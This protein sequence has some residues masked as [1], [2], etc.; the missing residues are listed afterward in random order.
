[1]SESPPQA[2]PLLD[3]LWEKG[4]ILFGERVQQEYGLHTPIF[5]DL[6]H[7]L[8]D[9]LELLTQL[10]AALHERLRSIVQAESSIRPQQ[11]IGIP[12]TATPIALSVA[13][14]SQ[15]TDLPVFY[16]QMR[17]KP[18]EYPGGAS[19]LSSYMGTCDK[20]REV[21]LIDDVMASGRT[22]VWAISELR[23]DGLDVKRVL[24]VVDREQGGNHVLKDLGCPVYNLYGVSS[25]IR[26]YEAT[27][28]IGAATASA[29]L[30]HVRTKQ[31]G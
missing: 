14:Q 24:V 7:K 20:R 5:I 28:K 11:V 12:D 10:G 27:E 6:R 23:K 19:G 17:K 22:K 29:A 8:Y 2:D 25:L 3:A 21:T 31:F 18:A 30:A 4:L 9:H 15:R 13:L 16:G 1:M 26:Y